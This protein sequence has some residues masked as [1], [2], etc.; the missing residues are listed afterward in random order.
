MFRM[1]TIAFENGSTIPRMYTQEGD[2]ISPPLKWVD[3]PEG[4]KAYALIVDDPDAPR[5]EPWVHWVLYGIPGDTHE[6]IEGNADDLYTSGCN[7]AGHHHYDGP[8][9][10]PGHGVHQYHFK[11][12][13]LSDELDLQPGATKKDLLRAMDGYILAMTEIVGTYER[14]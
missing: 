5:D 1:T 4:T 10:P 12:Y 7:T 2:N 14:T 13:A 11:L 3:A 8:M 6:L 9:P